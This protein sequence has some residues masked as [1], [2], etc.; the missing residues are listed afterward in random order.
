[1]PIWLWIAN[2]TLI[3]LFDYVNIYLAILNTET[4]K[5]LWK[6]LLGG[7]LIFSDFLSHRSGI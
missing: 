4:P 3:M 7:T 1:M 5:H 6:D 2:T